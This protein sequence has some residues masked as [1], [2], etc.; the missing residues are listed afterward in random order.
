MVLKKL[1]MLVRPTI[2][3]VWLG[4]MWH[5]SIW[6]FSRDLRVKFNFGSWSAHMIYV[7]TFLSNFDILILE[8]ETCN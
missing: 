6:A 4:L 2:W 1:V 3:T 8:F 5:A 7:L